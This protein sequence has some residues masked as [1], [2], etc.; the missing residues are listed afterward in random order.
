MCSVPVLREGSF[1]LLRLLD[2]VYTVADTITPVDDH[3]SAGHVPDDHLD[4]VLQVNY[5]ILVA[6]ICG[7]CCTVLRPRSLLTSDTSSFAAISVMLS[8]SEE[9]V[10]AK[11]KKIATTDEDATERSLSGWRWI[12]LKSPKGPKIEGL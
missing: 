9:H 10:E 6:L 4:Q 3:S 1:L 12:M 8:T 7:S 5:T 11:L 2:Y